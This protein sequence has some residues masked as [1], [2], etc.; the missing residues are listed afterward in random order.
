MRESQEVGLLG[1]G[2]PSSQYSN[3]NNSFSDNSLLNN[4][5]TVKSLLQ[6]SKYSKKQLVNDQKN[7]Q[8]SLEII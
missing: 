8:N 1:T 5:Y 7:N 6:K 2:S 3:P 4:S